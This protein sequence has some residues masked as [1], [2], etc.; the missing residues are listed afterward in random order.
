[1]KSLYTTSRAKMDNTLYG[2]THAS[3]N[4]SFT[5]CG[6]YIDEKWMILTNNYDGKI[7]CRKCASIEA[8]RGKENGDS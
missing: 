3:S 6:S 2:L 5:L 1:M 7:T 4:A 8:E